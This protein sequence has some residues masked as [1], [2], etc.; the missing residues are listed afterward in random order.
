[1]K[2]ITTLMAMTCLLISSCSKETSEPNSPSNNNPGKSKKELIT[3]SWRLVSVID[4]TPG[5]GS[6]DLLKDCRKDDTWTFK[7][8]G[9]YQIDAGTNYCD[10]NDPSYE[11]SAGVWNID[12]YPLLVIKDNTNITP[13]SDTIN[14]DLLDET[15]LRYSQEI[16][17]DGNTYTTT[18]T[19]K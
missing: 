2:R 3:N 19:R 11:T 13:H 14:I 12:S 5:S 17:N 9:T 4:N 16:D 10:P 15:T 6:P 18:W 1:M 7:A 8:D